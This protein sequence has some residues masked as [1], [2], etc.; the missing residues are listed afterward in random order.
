VLTA[1]QNRVHTLEYA[2]PE[3]PA[4]AEA[5][6][7]LLTAET[8]CYW[9]WTGQTVWDEQVTRA[10]N[11]G[12]ALIDSALNDLMAA[13][14]DRSGPTIFP[15]WVT[16]ENPGGKRWGQGC[17]LDAPREGTAHC[18]VADVSDLKRV[19][20]ILRSTAGEQR[21]PMRDHGA[22]PSQTGAR[23]TAN[24]FTAELPVGLGDVRYFIEAEDA[25]GNVARG[26]LER[27]FLA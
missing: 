5:I 9:Y 8:S 21:L 25:R 22:Y 10:A 15:P 7:L 2:D 13:E 16:P 12:N 3:N 17:L 18:F 27:I 1:F 4:L 6:R 11:L 24:Y 23:I 26:G 14:H 20:L 19:E